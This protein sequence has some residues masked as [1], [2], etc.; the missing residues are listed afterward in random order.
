MAVHLRF[1]VWISD[2][3]SSHP[4]QNGWRFN[5]CFDGK[6]AAEKEAFWYAQHGYTLI[7]IRMR[8]SRFQRRE[9]MTTGEKEP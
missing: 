4:Y 7:D 6:S 1:E 9:H 5:G 2:T 8:T 3:A